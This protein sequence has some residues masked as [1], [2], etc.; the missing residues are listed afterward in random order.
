[1]HNC[2]SLGDVSRNCMLINVSQCPEEQTIPGPIN[3]YT[4][5]GDAVCEMRFQVNRALLY[6]VQ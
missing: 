6:L 3:K 1:M 5:V 4:A 2:A